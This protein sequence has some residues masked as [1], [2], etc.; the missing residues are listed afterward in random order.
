MEIFN[1]KAAQVALK[2]L[3]VQTFVTHFTF[4]AF[5]FFLLVFE[6]LCEAFQER[7]R[8]ES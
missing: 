3:G 8:Q 1:W 7:V 2:Q 4:E 6:G 5:S